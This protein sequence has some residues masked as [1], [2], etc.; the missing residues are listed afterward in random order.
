MWKRFQR[1]W[2]VSV[3]RAEV[4]PSDE[5]MQVGSEIG[6]F[7][8]SHLMLILA[9]AMLFASHFEK[10]SIVNSVIWS[11]LGLVNSLAANRVRF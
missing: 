3:Q 7:V 1:Y 4:L 10:R 11:V 2:L 5:R 6:S 9:L 8:T